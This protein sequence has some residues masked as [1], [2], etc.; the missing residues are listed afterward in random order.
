MVLDTFNRKFILANLKVNDFNIQKTA[1]AIN[2]NRQDLS[3][4]VKSLGL[5]RGV[6]DLE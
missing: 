1:R 6:N 3:T 5:E 2:Y 4:L